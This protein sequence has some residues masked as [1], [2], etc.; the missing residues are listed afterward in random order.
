MKIL[1]FSNCLLDHA[2]GS[3][4]TRLAWADGLRSLGH[5]VTS[6]ESLALLGGSEGSPGGRRVRLVWGALQWLRHGDLAKFDLIEFYG[7][8]FWLATGWL[9][10]RLVRPVLVAH[11]D[12]LEML[13]EERLS[14]L[15]AGSG[16]SE[17]GAKAFVR[18]LRSRLEKMAFSKVDG[19]V[20]ASGADGEYLVRHGIRER[21][22]IEVVP[23][24]LERAYLGLS[25]KTAREEKVVFL[26]SWIERKGTAAL[27][28]VMVPLLRERPALGFDLYGVDLTEID[29]LKDFPDELHGRIRVHPRLPIPEIIAGL[30]TAKVFFFPSEYEGFGLALAEAMACGCA[31]VTTATGFGADLRS[32][33][34]A[35]VTGFGDVGAMKSAIERLLDD[36]P[37]R[38]RIAGAGWQRVQALR[39]ESSV[40]QLEGVYTRWVEASAHRR[41]SG[42]TPAIAN[43]ARSPI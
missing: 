31:A 26:G 37:F 19:F 5:E 2:S 22:T 6:V 11:T 33:E 28:A 20:T 34:D 3:G 24:G 14:P 8:E 15:R 40:R 41:L 35:V 39:W 25:W 1:S 16:A 17:T 13:A 43:P 29:P 4:R 23:L 30:L 36:E 18:A 10:R 12:G 7:A 21:S 9:A 42:Q 38:M 27:T 32:D